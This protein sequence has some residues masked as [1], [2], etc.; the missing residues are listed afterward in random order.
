MISY[1]QKTYRWYGCQSRN[2]STTMSGSS[3]S[4]ELFIVSSIDISHI[5]TSEPIIRGNIHY[6]AFGMLLEV[7]DYGAFW[8]GSNRWS[9]IFVP[10]HTFNMSLPNIKGILKSAFSPHFPSFSSWWREISTFEKTNIS[11]SLNDRRLHTSQ[12]SHH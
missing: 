7:E 8:W 5:F 6:L 12:E 10:P 9:F 4:K 3:M 11:T 2:R 1:L